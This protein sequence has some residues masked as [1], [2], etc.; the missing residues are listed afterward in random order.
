MST[1]VTVIVPE[2]IAGMFVLFQQ[3]YDNF[4]K[5]L[6]AGALDQK[7]AAITLNFDKNGVLQTIDRRDNIYSRRHALST[8]SK[9]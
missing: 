4:S 3:H 6:E 9:G 8:D 1:E 2:K 5:L 7:N